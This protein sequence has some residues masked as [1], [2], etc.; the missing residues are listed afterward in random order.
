M[1]AFMAGSILERF[2]EEM[3]VLLLFLISRGWT[4]KGRHVPARH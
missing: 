4:E 3:A 2:R 1:Q